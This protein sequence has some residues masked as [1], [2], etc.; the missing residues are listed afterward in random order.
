M[1]ISIN[2]SAKGE[3]LVGDATYGIVHRIV[4]HREGESDTGLI[5]R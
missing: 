4:F 2:R 3:T 1:C 5:V